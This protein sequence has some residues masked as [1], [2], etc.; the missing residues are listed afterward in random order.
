MVGVVVGRRIAGLISLFFLFSA[1]SWSVSD[2]CGLF[3]GFLIV[4]SRLRW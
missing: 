3:F 2:S 1:E 4:A